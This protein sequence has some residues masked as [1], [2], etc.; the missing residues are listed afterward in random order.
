MTKLTIFRSVFQRDFVTNLLLQMIL[1][2]DCAVVMEMEAF[3][4]GGMVRQ[5]V[6][7]VLFAYD[8]ILKYS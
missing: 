1:V 6:S 3:R 7:I 4:V 8:L 2:M 5:L